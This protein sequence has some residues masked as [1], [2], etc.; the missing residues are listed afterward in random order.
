MKSEKV[1]IHSGQC[2]P[3]LARVAYGLTDFTDWDSETM[4]EDVSLE[5]LLT[6]GF[7]I[8]AHYEEDPSVYTA[9]SNIPKS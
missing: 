8:N 9:C 3:N 6:V 7:A 2:G 5:S 4:L 1:H